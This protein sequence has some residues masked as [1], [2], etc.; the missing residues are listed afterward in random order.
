MNY[1]LEN[2]YLKLTVSS[3]GAEPI[4]II[5]KLDNAE[6]LWSGD[7][8]IWGRHAPILFPYTGKLT[9]GR[10]IAKGREYKGGQHGFARDMEHVLVEQSDEK[11]VLELRSDEVTGEKFPYAF[12]LRSVFTLE[13][14]TVHHTL[15]VENPGEEV[16]RFGIGYHPAFVCPFDEDH[17][18]ED[19]EFRFEREESPMVIGVG[20]SG[21][22]DGT[23]GYFGQ[24]IKTIQLTD[25]LFDNDSFCMAGLTGNTLGIYEK[26]SGRSVVCNIAAYPYTLIWSK[27]TEKVKFVCIEPWH[28]LPGVEGGSCEWDQRAAAAS[29]VSG[30]K[31]STTLSMTFNR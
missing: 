23:C 27:N 17:D 10:F 29:L 2:N 28:S 12:I 6:C 4:S 11:L 19:Y 3:H 25:H 13:G 30:E 1:T 16:L 9:E 26:N 18:T 8:E 31:F 14:N 22:L 5:S 7:P 20:P 24:N 15:E 21:L